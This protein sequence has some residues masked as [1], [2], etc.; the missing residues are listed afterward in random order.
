MLIERGDVIFAVRWC[1]TFFHYGVYVGNNQVIHYNTNDD[2]D[3]TWAHN[4]IIKTS[5]DAFANGD[6]V[7][8][9]SYGHRAS[10]ENTAQEAEKLLGS[11][12]G[13]YHLVT[14]NCEHFCNL[15]RNGSKTSEQVWKAGWNITWKALQWGKDIYNVFKATDFG[16][17]LAN[18]LAYL[19]IELL[20]YAAKGLVDLCLQHEV[21][22]I[23][24][25]FNATKVD[26]VK[27]SVAPFG[28]GLDEVFKRCPFCGAPMPK[29]ENRCIFCGQETQEPS[30]STSTKAHY[31]ME[32]SKSHG[33]LSLMDM[34][35]MQI[36][37]NHQ[38]I[39][40]QQMLQ[41]GL[42]YQIP[43]QIYTQSSP[44]T[45][46]KPLEYPYYKVSINGQVMMP[47]S[48]NDVRQMVKQG[49]IQPTT[50]VWIIQKEGDTSPWNHAKDIPE[51]ANLFNA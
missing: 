48:L 45:P 8:L 46:P 41:K 22:N 42:R 26:G 36:M 24:H 4:S 25:Q 10:K 15:C 50:C 34:M 7:Y 11:G 40:Q 47:L 16:T 35:A 9:E 18:P 6:P 23:L 1:G 20:V 29:K 14:N 33:S 31:S 2:M 28:Y 30:D 38:Q 19:S 3:Y 12:K 51:L 39:M 17:F 21:D 27:I 32:N 49:K 5:F 43:T 13:D 37:S 44:P